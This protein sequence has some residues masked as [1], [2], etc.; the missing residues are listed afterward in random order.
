MIIEITKNNINKYSNELLNDEELINNL[1]N[2]PYGNYIAYIDD[3]LIGYIYY[4]KIYDRLEINNILVAESRRREGIA[5]KL[6]NYLLEKENLPI[7]LEVDETN[8]KAINLYKKIGFKE[9]SIRK[10]YYGN[11]DGIL[12]EKR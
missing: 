4:S 5:S 8:N 11:H 7:T 1:D 12:M 2:N 9:V 10:N 6:F 3:T